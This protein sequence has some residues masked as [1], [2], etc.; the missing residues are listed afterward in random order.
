MYLNALAHLSRRKRQ[1][2]PIVGRSC[3]C[4]P[5]ANQ[6]V[7]PR[8]YCAVRR[9]HVKPLPYAAVDDVCACMR[10]CVRSPARDSACVRLCVRWIVPEIDGLPE[11][12]R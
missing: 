11:T 12:D 4:S 7:L 5:T 9:R 6:P 10:S 8:V 2:A 1:N 3:T